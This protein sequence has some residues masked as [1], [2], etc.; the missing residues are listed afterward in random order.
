MHLIS[1]SKP[2]RIVSCKFIDHGVQ[3]MKSLITVLFTLTFASAAVATD[4]IIHA[5]A[6]IDGVRDSVREEVTIKIED[7]KIVSVEDGYKRSRGEV[8]DLK[9]HT[10]MPGLMDMH[11]HL[12]GERSKESH[13]ET[14]FMNPAD[15]A[16]RST[17]YARRTLMAGF[18]TV[19]DLGD[20]GVTVVSL[21]N[22]IAKGWVV[23]PR[24]F[25]AGKSLATT[26]GHADPTNGR[27][28][29]LKGDPG[30][31]EGVI[32]GVEDARKAVRQRYKDGADLIKLTGTGGVLSLAKSG[33]NPQFQMDELKAIVETAKDYDFTV[34]VHAHGSEGMKRAVLAGVDSIEHGTYMTEEVMDLMIERGTYYV[35]TIV[36]GAFVAEKAKEDGYFPEIVRPKAAAIGPVIQGTFAKA[37]KRGVKIAFGTDSGVSPHGENGKEFGLMVEGGMPAMK[38]IQSAT[39]ETAKLL[40]I[41]DTLGSVEA[42]K[43]ADLVAVK[44]NPLKNI[45]LMESISFVMKEGVVYKNKS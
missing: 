10:V 2:V 39:M 28:A 23:G 36:A 34:A 21:R 9:N 20:D 11:T 30:P 22:A 33:Q 44:G 7:G 32:N 25:T 35:P 17:V 41:S 38:T 8:I 31:K 24:I 12:S 4:T 26:G 29:E 45:E 43:I 19:R 18:T 6:L 40:R 16:L 5:G 15:Y 14:F 13:Y 27:K 37:Y 3:I 1:C 42:G